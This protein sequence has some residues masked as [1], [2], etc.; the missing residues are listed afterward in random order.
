MTSINWG[1]IFGRTK[2]PPPEVKAEGDC[3]G[4]GHALEDHIRGVCIAFLLH[5]IEDCGCGV[6]LGQME[7]PFR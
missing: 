3:P 6:R 1:E 4:C 5:N 7:M 2:E